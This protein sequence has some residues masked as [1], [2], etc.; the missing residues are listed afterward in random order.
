MEYHLQRYFQILKVVLLVI[1]ARVNESIIIKLYNMTMLTSGA[2]GI[3][4]S[5]IP[6]EGI[7][8]KFSSTWQVLGND[9]LVCFH[10]RSHRFKDE[11]RSLQ[12][13]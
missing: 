5:W 3:I 8:F 2:E 11:K 12:Q 1:L 6:R 7:N 10:H 9:I 4:I 13:W